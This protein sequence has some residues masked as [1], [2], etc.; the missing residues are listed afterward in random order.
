MTKR[1]PVSS[2]HIV[3]TAGTTATV[4]RHP[5]D[6]S[7][8]QPSTLKSVPS[9]SS[10][11]ETVL[12]PAMARPP[13]TIHQQPIHQRVASSPQRNG[14]SDVGSRHGSEA[15]AGGEVMDRQRIGPGV[16]R[17]CP[18]APDIVAG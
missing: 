3:K 13:P 6:G 5:A 8:H 7:T 9:P 17:R 2:N 10:Q 14:S 16:P 1:G 18:A 11:S 4:R 15:G 12:E